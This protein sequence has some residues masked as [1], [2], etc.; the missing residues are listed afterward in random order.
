MNILL[1]FQLWH[2]IDKIDCNSFTLLKETKAR[3]LQQCKSALARQS[4]AQVSMGQR[5]ENIANTVTERECTLSRKLT[6]NATR[7]RWQQKSEYTTKESY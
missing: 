7:Y 3:L 1:K 4:G 6:L 5:Q 2:L